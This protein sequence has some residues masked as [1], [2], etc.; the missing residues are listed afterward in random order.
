MGDTSATNGAQRID[1]GRDV[2]VLHAGRHFVTGTAENNERL[3]ARQ[4]V[5]LPDDVYAQVLDEI[6]PT[7][8]DL[9]L[10]TEDKL[11]VLLGKRQQEPQP[12]WWLIGGRKRTR[13]C[14][15]DTAAR[16]A[17]RELGIDLDL[18]RLD[19]RPLGAFSLVWD[20][21][22]QG[23]VFNGCHTT[24]LPY[25]YFVTA[26]ELEAMVPNQEYAEVRLWHAS[27]ITNDGQFHPMLTEVLQVAFETFD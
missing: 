18:A 26:A 15:A 10:I 5:L 24:S 21:R 14:D 27:E 7:C 20:T 9:L 19:R 1:Y 17:K 16:N 22:A 3:G 12:D 6:V 8:V 4:R 25:I 2:Q 11:R 13:E 23:E